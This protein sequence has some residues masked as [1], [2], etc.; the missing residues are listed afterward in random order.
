VPDRCIRIRN[1]GDITPV[2]IGE[3]DGTDPDPNDSSRDIRFQID[4]SSLAGGSFHVKKGGTFYPNNT[5]FRSQLLSL[6][7]AHKV[8]FVDTSGGKPPLPKASAQLC[9]WADCSPLTPICFD[10]VPTAPND[11][12]KIAINFSIPLGMITT[13][14]GFIGYRIRHAGNIR[15]K[16]GQLGYLQKDHELF[17]TEHWK[18]K[19]SLGNLELT[20]RF[21]K[22]LYTFLGFTDI[23]DINSLEGKRYLRQVARVIREARKK[24][25]QISD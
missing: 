5:F 13:I 3:L 6:P 23:E 16:R 18:N 12:A 2:T 1:I 17:N 15:R 25:I 24:G 8:E 4:S 21:S 7:P 10:Y 14:F 19:Q 11:F 22:R 9:D 20:Y